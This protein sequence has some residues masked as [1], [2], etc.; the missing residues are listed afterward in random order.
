[1]YL[2]N[3]HEK[4]ADG[5]PPAFPKPFN[6]VPPD[7]NIEPSVKTADVGPGAVVH[8]CEIFGT[9]GVVTTTC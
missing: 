7:K 2:K 5:I 9:E 4:L 3:H 8:S 1:M 6:A